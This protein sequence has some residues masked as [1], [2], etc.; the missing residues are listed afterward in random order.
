[1]LFVILIISLLLLLLSCLHQAVSISVNVMKS[2]H[3]N[4]TTCTSITGMCRIVVAGGGWWSQTRHIPQLHACPNACVVAVIEPNSEPYSPMDKLLDMV[5]LTQT[6]S[7][8]VFSS[9]ESFMEA[10]MEYDGV[11]ICTSHATHHDLGI[12]F[13]NAKKHILIEKPMTISVQESQVRSG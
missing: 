11:V 7:V 12:T 13:L 10:G 9:V 1:M 3:D 4:Q 6:Y 8:P 2:S 5:T